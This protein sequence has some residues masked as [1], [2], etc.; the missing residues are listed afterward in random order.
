V[1]GWG[2]YEGEGGEKRREWKKRVEK[3]VGGKESGVRDG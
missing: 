2:R 1:K 3:I